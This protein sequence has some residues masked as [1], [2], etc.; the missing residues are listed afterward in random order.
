[1]RWMGTFSSEKVTV[2]GANLLDTLCARLEKL[3]SFQLGERD[4][5]TLQH[6]FVVERSDQKQYVLTL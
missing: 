6:K 5:V 1:M 4:L 2:T 3:M